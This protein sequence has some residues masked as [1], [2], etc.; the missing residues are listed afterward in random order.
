MPRMV[1]PVLLC[2]RSWLSTKERVP[3]FYGK[4]VKEKLVMDRLLGLQFVM[5]KLKEKML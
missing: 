5:V 4:P 1:L 2:T 3:A